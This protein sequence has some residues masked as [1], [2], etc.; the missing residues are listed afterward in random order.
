MWHF[1]QQYFGNNSSFVKDS[2]GLP[3]FLKEQKV[4]LDETLVSFDVTALFT[5]IPVFVAEHFL[6]N[7]DL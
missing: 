5:S 1:L 2:K 3:E 7:F 4:A 6:E